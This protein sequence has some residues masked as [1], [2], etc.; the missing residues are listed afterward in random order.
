MLSKIEKPPGGSRV[1][2]FRPSR[3]SI[4]DLGWVWS[5]TLLAAAAGILTQFIVAR[6]L[7]PDAFG[8]FSS[9][10]GLAALAAPVA[11]FGV[12]QYWLK[13]FG[14]EGWAALRWLRPGL[15]FFAMSSAA[16]LVIL[17]AWALLGPN[18]DQSTFV[19]LALMV[20][21][22]SAALVEIVATKFQLEQRYGQFAFLGLITPLSR[23]VIAGVAFFAFQPTYELRGLSLGYAAIS[24]AIMVALAPQ[25]RQLWRK[26]I[27][28]SGHG[29]AIRIDGQASLPVGLLLS[30]SWVFGLAGLLYLAWAQAHI[31]FAK[32]ALGNEAAGLYGSALILMNAICLLPTTLFSKFLLPKI[33]RWASQ[34]ISRLKEF[35]RLSSLIMFSGGVLAAV[36]IFFLSDVLIRIAFGEGYE[37]A[38]LLLKVLSCTLPM[39]FLGYNAGAMLRTKRFMQIK[40]AILVLSAAFNFALA[41]LFV[42]RWGLPGLVATVAITEFFLVSSYVLAVKF[43]YFKN[44]GKDKP[45]TDL[46]TGQAK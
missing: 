15:R 25:A 38:T 32:Y 9:A 20:T 13:A 1:C 16:V 45:M 14:E 39:R 26:E 18:D 7:Q 6:L 46:P 12:G 2:R 22:F 35:S 24:I 5:G 21:A 3:R 10:L 4:V 44:L 11:V 29:P 43:F 40:V 30:E 27:A 36:L 31:V 33:H 37:N 28:L 8:V 34:D 42:S 17:A 19:I 41:I 23:L